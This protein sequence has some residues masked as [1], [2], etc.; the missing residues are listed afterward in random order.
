MR[1]IWN[2][3]SELNNAI[4]SKGLNMLLNISHQTNLYYDNVIKNNFRNFCT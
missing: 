4:L 2:I 1:I 3:F